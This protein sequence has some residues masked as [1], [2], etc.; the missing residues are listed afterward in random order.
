MSL[1]HTERKMSPQATALHIKSQAE[2]QTVWW[3]DRPVISTIHPGLSVISM[4]YLLS[5][6]ICAII[7][8]I[9]FING[10]YYFTKTRHILIWRHELSNTFN[11]KNH[12]GVL[13]W[14]RY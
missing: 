12:V 6:M 5:N 1:K 4:I 13:L 11:A 9:F 2:W 8:S 14:I 10:S 3:V 7:F